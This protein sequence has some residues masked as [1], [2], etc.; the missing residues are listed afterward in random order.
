MEVKSQKLAITP[1]SF[2]A[3]AITPSSIT[4][5]A[6]KRRLGIGHPTDQI[7]KPIAETTW[8]SP[9]PPSRSGAINE[10]VLIRSLDVSR[11][12]FAYC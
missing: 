7:T 4:N 5:K 12:A 9:P 11:L 8:S 2:D 3:E 6:C 1:S 10:I